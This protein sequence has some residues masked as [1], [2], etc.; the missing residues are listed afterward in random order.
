MFLHTTAV[1]YLIKVKRAEPSGTVFDLLKVKSMKDG[2]NCRS[3]VIA[4]YF[5]KGLR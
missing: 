3:N 2:I 4:S 5:V 1:K